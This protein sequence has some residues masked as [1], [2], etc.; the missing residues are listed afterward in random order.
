MEFQRD[1]PQRLVGANTV[2]P[3]IVRKLAEKKK[4]GLA[5]GSPAPCSLGLGVT[6]M[7]GMHTIAHH[8]LASLPGVTVTIMYRL[9]QY[10]QMEKRAAKEQLPQ[11][12]F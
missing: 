10:G 4:G 12:N 3:V 11:L 7:Y 6:V 8:F 1:Q 9:Y 2:I 5:L